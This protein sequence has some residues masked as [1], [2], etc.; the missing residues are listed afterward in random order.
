MIPSLVGASTVRDATYV[1][2]M[3][4][5]SFTIPDGASGDVSWTLINDFGSIGDEHRA[6]L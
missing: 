6:R 4:D 2:P 1:A 5:A 3:S